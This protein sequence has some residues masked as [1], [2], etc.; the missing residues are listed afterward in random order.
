MQ[1][2]F[3]FFMNYLAEACL[4]ASTSG[5]PHWFSSALNR[6]VTIRLLILEQLTNLQLFPQLFF[7]VIIWE[8]SISGT[9]WTP[10]ICLPSNII[11]LLLANDF[12]LPPHL[13]VFIP[14]HN[15]AS[16]ETV[17]NLRSIQFLP[18]LCPAFLSCISGGSIFNIDALGGGYI[19]FSDTT[20]TGS[21][22][23]LTCYDS[24]SYLMSYLDSLVLLLLILFHFALL[25]AS[26]FGHFCSRHTW[27]SCS[28]STPKDTAL[29]GIDLKSSTTSIFLNPPW[30]RR[31]TMT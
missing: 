1:E 7:L 15:I 12:L 14:V 25:R 18:Y 10:Y 21:F 27:N 19:V 17:L 16:F 6:A 11:F 3:P 13:I 31:L 26:C 2:Q 30:R 29:H 8:N 23:Q 24:S 4:C 20:S 5:E 9:L 28:L 22:L